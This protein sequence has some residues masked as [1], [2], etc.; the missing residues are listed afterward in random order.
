VCPVSTGGKGGGGASLRREAAVGADARKA[1][2]VARERRH[3]R[4][5]PGRVSRRP[6]RIVFISWTALN[7]FAPCRGVTGR[8]AA[9]ERVRA[10]RRAPEGR[11]SRAATS[12]A[13]GRGWEGRGAGGRPVLL[14]SMR[15][16]LFVRATA[17]RTKASA[18]GWQV[19][20]SQIKSK[21]FSSRLTER[22]GRGGKEPSAA[23]AARAAL[24]APLVQGGGS[25]RREFENATFHGGS[26]WQKRVAKRCV[27]EFTNTD[28][29]AG[30]RRRR[31]SRH[32][33][34]AGTPRKPAAAR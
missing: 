34:A 21:R 31:D 17:S 20:L 23:H 15:A 19:R 26:A 7:A 22:G 24:F 33:G 32:R 1:R 10:G 6:C 16:P 18:R 11:A 5:L 12:G 14:R 28:G 8:R 3:L 29:A 9:A 13:S 27:F 2:E 30:R 25:A 4:R